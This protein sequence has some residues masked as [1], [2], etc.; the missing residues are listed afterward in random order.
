MLGVPEEPNR[1][2]QCP[3]SDKGKRGHEDF[4]ETFCCSVSRPVHVSSE[5]NNF[6]EFLYRHID[7]H[8]FGK[9]QVKKLFEFAP[10]F[11][12]RIYKHGKFLTR[13]KQHKM[14]DEGKMVKLEN[15]TTWCEGIPKPSE[16]PNSHGS[17]LD[18]PE[19]DKRNLTKNFEN[20]P[21]EVPF[22]RHCSP[23]GENKFETRINDE[24]N[25]VFI[26]EATRRS[27][28][29]GSKFNEFRYTESADELKLLSSDAVN[30]RTDSSKISGSFLVLLLSRR[31][32][33]FL[34]VV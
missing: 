28:D 20:L 5:N 19:K 21:E 34:S 27:N 30:Q 31:M 33:F 14:E 11:A 9:Q 23:S 2:K 25:S 17:L 1:G 18:I 22:L 12:L 3:V 26:Q 4:V 10:E 7:T 24:D 6:D 29:I 13:N 32:F 16:R 8:F 15:V